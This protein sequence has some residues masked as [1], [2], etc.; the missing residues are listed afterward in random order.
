M[1]NKTP[2]ILAIFLV[3]IVFSSITGLTKSR[4]VH[5]IDNGVLL[6][7]H[8]R[9]YWGVIRL[10]EGMENLLRRKDSKGDGFADCLGAIFYIQLAEDT[11]IVT[12]DGI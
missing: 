1:I 4:Y 6:C 9:V 5:Y 11:T 2:T 7:R 12:F 3:L 8:L 10:A